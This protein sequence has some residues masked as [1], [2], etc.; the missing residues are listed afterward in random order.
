MSSSPERLEWLRQL[1]LDAGRLHAEQAARRR[2]LVVRHKGRVDLVTE[3]DRIIEDFVVGRIRETF[4]QD[5]VVAEERDLET[6][7]RG[8]A[9][10]WYVDPIDGTTNFVHGH[11]FS[12]I[13]VA[14]WEG[15]DP[16]LG[17][18][19]AP[20]LDE[21]YLGRVGGGAWLERPLRGP[22]RERLEVSAR[23]EIDEALVATG[24]PYSRGALARLNLELTARVLASCQGI[25]RAGSAAL[26]LCWVAAGRLDVYWEFALKPW[27]VA[28][29]LI[30]AG[31]A[32]ARLGDFETE[33]LPLSGRRVCVAT[34][35]LFDPILQLLGEGHENPTLDVLAPPSTA[36]VPRRG[37]LPGDEE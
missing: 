7:D 37:P 5:A 34:P 16:D 14:R 8:R 3:A 30:I 27:D 33:C 2:E 28:A 10:T 26:D 31:E 19:F 32:G 36:P 20:E 23:T 29:G 12:C 25:R 22:Q 1:L 13:S 18:V 4:P 17:G 35:A 11:L 21:L 9:A 24:F 6:S 15:S